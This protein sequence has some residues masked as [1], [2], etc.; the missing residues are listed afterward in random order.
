MDPFWQ[1]TKTRF[2]KNT[3]C[4]T[5]TYGFNCLASRGAPKKWPEYRT[6]ARV[7]HPCLRHLGAT[8]LCSGF[9]RMASIKPSSPKAS[10]QTSPRDR[11]AASSEL[12]LE[13]GEALSNPHLKSF[14]QTKVLRSLAPPTKYKTPLSPKTHPKV[15]PKSSPEA[16]LQKKYVKENPRF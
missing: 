13:L 4:A 11:A 2:T 8:A 14:S 6:P 10:L 5:P 9:N 16:K 7:T 1:G 15:Y 12:H 3:V